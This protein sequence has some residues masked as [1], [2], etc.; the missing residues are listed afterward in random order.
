MKLSTN[1]LVLIL[2]LIFCTLLGGSLEA[3]DYNQSDANGLKQG[4][5]KK[6]HSNGNT[7]YKGQFKDN[8]PY[9][10]FKYYNTGGELVTVLEYTASD[11]AIATHYHTNSIKA[12]YGYYVNQKKEGV[13]RFY[14]KK[15]VI[16][17]KE[18]YK[19]GEKHGL[20]VVYNLDGSV[21]RETTFV[22]GVEEGLRKT[23]DRTGEI[24]T[25]GFVKDGQ[26]DGLQKTF[27]NGIIN[28]EGSYKH[29]VKD[30]E[31]LFYDADGKIYKKEYYE[32]GIKKN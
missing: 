26:M 6:K 20:Y 19:E 8:Q 15:G 32:L 1:N 3:Q 17:S 16:S 24:L 27:K 23:Y 9:G 18:T 10:I 21:S 14:D 28:V 30:G 11:T 29:A 2:T 7:K 31:W 25:E 12:A 22:N 4:L 13:W 5:W